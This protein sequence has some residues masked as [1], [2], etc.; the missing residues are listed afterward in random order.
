MYFGVKKNGQG[1]QPKI[2]VHKNE[3]R[4]LL[5]D[6]MK[7]VSGQREMERILQQLLLPPFRPQREFLKLKFE[8]AGS[9]H[10]RLIDIVL[11]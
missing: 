5:M 11:G 7:I 1:Y 2:L 9:L 6:K 10:L 4:K 8:M 3:E